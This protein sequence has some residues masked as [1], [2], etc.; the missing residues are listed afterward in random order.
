MNNK[1]FKLDESVNMSTSQL[2]GCGFKTNLQQFNKVATLYATSGVII[3]IITILSWSM[4]HH[5]INF[6]KILT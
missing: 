6:K 5:V 4:S 2:E 1:L 3:V